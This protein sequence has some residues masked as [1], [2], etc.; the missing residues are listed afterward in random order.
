MSAK[1]SL[2]QL[3]LLT[4]GGSVLGQQV[5][6]ENYDSPDGG[7]PADYFAADSSLAVD[8]IL[9]AVS[10]LSQVGDSYPITTESDK[11]S[12][13]FSDWASFDDVSCTCTG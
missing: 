5:N 11:E 3:A 8:K 2:F 10:K 9:S 7:P 4:L 1:L 13:I 12:Q 6:G